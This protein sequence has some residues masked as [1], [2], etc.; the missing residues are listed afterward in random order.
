[1]TSILLDIQQFLNL[2]DSRLWRGLLQGL[3]VLA[4][5]LLYTIVRTLTRLVQV[6][7]F[8]VET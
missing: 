8:D 1:M 6:E 2:F 4:V 5:I 3:V 7:A